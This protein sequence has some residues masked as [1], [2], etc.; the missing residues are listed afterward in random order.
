[1]GDADVTPEELHALRFPGRLRMVGVNDG[2][3]FESNHEPKCFDAACPGCREG[4][5]WAYHI[6]QTAETP[7]IQL[8]NKMAEIRTVLVSHLRSGRVHWTVDKY[9]A[10]LEAAQQA[11][12]DSMV[13]KRGGGPDDEPTELELAAGKF[14]G[15]GYLSSILNQSKSRR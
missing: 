15:R 14:L 3:P 6:P 4:A 9:P 8:A 10:L 13:A 2:Q 12:T 5:K 1:M 11:V 7:D